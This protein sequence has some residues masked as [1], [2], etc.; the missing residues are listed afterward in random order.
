MV[1]P[2]AQREVRRALPGLA[3]GLDPL[4]Q[5]RTMRGVPAARNPEAGGITL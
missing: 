1:R 5:D 3:F 2:V 4:C